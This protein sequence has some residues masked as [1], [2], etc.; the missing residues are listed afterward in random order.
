MR[1]DYWRITSSVVRPVGEILFDMLQLIYECKEVLT[2]AVA[3]KQYYVHM[4]GS[5]VTSDGG[6][7][8]ILDIEAYEDDLQNMLEVSLN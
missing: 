5:V 2:A 1:E 4:V 7:G 3:V 8:F 6:D